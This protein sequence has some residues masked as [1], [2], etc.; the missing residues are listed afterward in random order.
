V[1]LQIADHSGTFEAFSMFIEEQLFPL[2]WNGQRHF[3]ELGLKRAF[4]HLFHNGIKSGTDLLGFI[5]ECANS[6]DERFQELGKRLEAHNRRGSLVFI[7]AEAEPFSKIGGL[8]N[9]VYELPRE[10]VAMG[11]E[12]YVITP[13]YRHGDRK[14]VDKLRSA[15]KRHGIC[16]TGI[17]VRFKIMDSEYEAGVHS[18]VVDGVTYYLLDHYEFFDGLYWG[19]TAEEKLRRRIAFSRACAEVIATF[20]LHPLFTFTND[21]FSGIFNGIVRGDPFYSQN[22]NFSRT[23][24]VHIIHNVGWQY[25][26]SYNRFERGFDH[27]MLFNLPS[28]LAYEFTDPVF[29]SRIN[30]MAAGIRL[31]DR[32]ITVSPSYAK[33]IEIASDGLEKILFNV[34]GINNAIGRD[35]VG[36][37]KKRFRDS[38]FVH[39]FYPLLLEEIS[40]NESLRKK[41]ESRF[42][43][44][45]SGPDF[46]ATIKQKARRELVTRM[47]NKLLLQTKH[48]LTVDPDLVLFSMIHRIVDQKG[49]QLLLEA[50]EGVFNTLKYQGI[51]GGPLPSGDQRGEEIAAGLLNLSNFYRR[52]VSVNIGFVDVTEALLGSDVFLM[53]SMYEPGGISQLEAFACGCL[54]VARATGGLRDTVHP[55]VVRGRRIVGNGFLFADY[56]AGSFYDAMQRCASFFHTADDRTIQSARRKAENSMY[57]WDSSAREYIKDVYGL[58]EIIRVL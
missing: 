45:M 42:P 55:L 9:V 57:Y 26:D 51:I 28:H 7:S 36:R 37:V 56:T 18:G 50:S 6:S 29:E 27:F 21:A 48:N 17:N 11:E 3:L 10:L 15:V 38:G 46:C 49:F 23:S 14:Q 31:A 16:Y 58:K 8:A 32:V 41:I 22:E 2:F 25:F 1:F 12:V 5:D 40:K 30:C 35:F 24:F 4:Y 39:T 44:I 34:K 33:Q 20:G 53:P 13:L 54:V 52:S 19:Y 43:E 47:R